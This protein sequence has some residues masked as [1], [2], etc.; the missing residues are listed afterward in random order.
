MM[1]E[2]QGVK[3]TNYVWVYIDVLHV[4]QETSNAT[5]PF[6]QCNHGS[7]K[8]MVKKNLS[9]AQDQNER[10]AHKV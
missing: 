9:F 8:I 1:I 3:N 7:T 2:S 4:N 10:V 6:F 5:Q